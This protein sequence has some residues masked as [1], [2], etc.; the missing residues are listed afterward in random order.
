MF[1]GRS[2]LAGAETNRA[3]HCALRNR[4]GA[5]ATEFVCPYIGISVMDVINNR[6]RAAETAGSFSKGKPEDDME[7]DADPCKE[8]RVALRNF[9][10]QPDVVDWNAATPDIEAYPSYSNKSSSNHTRT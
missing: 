7:V 6:E 3:R 9:G 4:G 2:L 10:N 8:Q 5:S 1:F